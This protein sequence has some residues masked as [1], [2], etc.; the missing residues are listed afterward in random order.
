[1]ALLAAVGSYDVAYSVSL[2]RLLHDEPHLVRPPFYLAEGSGRIQV[3]DAAAIAA[4]LRRGDEVISVDR[5]PYSGEASL[6][7]LLHASHPGDAFHVVVRRGG[8]TWTAHIRLA[9]VPAVAHPLMRWLFYGFTNILTPALCLVLGFAV[10]L[11]RRT[12]PLAWMLLALMT[13]FANLSANGDFAFTVLW[14]WHSPF[15]EAGI[16]YHIASG[17][18]WPIWLLLFGIYFPERLP[19]DARF[20]WFKWIVTAPIAAAALLGATISIL[21][22]DI[23][24]VERH[25]PLFVRLRDASFYFGMIAVGGFFAC[26][27]AKRAMTRNPDAQRRLRL[28]NAGAFTAL[29]PLFLVVI[30]GLTLGFDRVPEWLWAPSFFLLAAFPA[31]LAYV[32]VVHRAMDLRAV[33]RLGLQY[34]FAQRAI[35]ALQWLLAAGFLYGAFRLVEEPGGRAW[36]LALVALVVALAVR[37]KALGAWAQR[38]LDRRFFREAYQAERV[39]GELS[40]EVGAI[41]ETGPLLETVA[42]RLTGTFHVPRIAMLVEDDGHYR[43]AFALGFSGTQDSTFDRHAGVAA[44]LRASARP[45]RVYLDDADSWVYR[46]NGI[47]EREIAQLRALDTQLLLPLSARGGMIGFI[48]LGPKRSEEPYSIADLNLL[49]SVASQTGLALENSRLAEQIAA[50]AVQRERLNRELEIAREVQ[51]RLFPQSLP[52]VPGL[53]CAGTCRPALG[54]GG[55]YYDFLDLPEGKL[56]IAIG[57]VSGKGI[58]AALLMASLQASLRS[59]AIDGPSDLARLMTNLNRLLFDAT[60]SSRYATVFYGQYDPATRDFVYV[61]AGHNPPMLFRG[62]EVI[63]L[64]E[65]GPVV[66]LFRA[67]TYGQGCIRLEPRDTLVLFTDGISEA[68]DA[69]E[70]EWGE[71]ALIEAVR[72]SPGL[73]V[74]AMI[75]RLI[76]EAD[77]FVRGAP[78]NDDMTLL[79]IRVVEPAA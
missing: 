7:N 47:G 71:E 59:Q 37:L 1:M 49:G 36:K 9:A 70:E 11:I 25:F 63:R 15:R 60:L 45:L 10:V 53:E 41:R 17:S 73:P 27:G 67:A 22:S 5:R 14:S 76:A 2:V 43:S 26:L 19:L 21:D 6:L 39:M 28:L 58:P 16:A 20:P 78:Q 75:E 8:W 24:N 72:G 38:W 48:S 40:Q 74:G 46:E 30:A 51:Q 23:G 35:L 69:E 42:R 79:A 32:I 29:T 34:A 57:D 56:G 61:N 54:V 65:G 12:D 3:L 68:M 18:V 4:G 50:E 13:S 52:Q 31:T 55:D 66:G 77:R 62:A 33:L 64:E 44:A